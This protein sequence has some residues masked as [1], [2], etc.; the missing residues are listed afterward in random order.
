M[1]E[2]ASQLPHPILRYIAAKQ[3]GDPAYSITS[4]CEQCGISRGAY[5][6]LLRGDADVGTDL[7]EKVELGTC[8]VLT[9]TELY[10][11]W[12]HARRNPK[13]KAET[14]APQLPPVEA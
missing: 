4:F 2:A 11:A 9:C 7:F 3:Q 10:S 8:F 5:Y 1:T 13:P 12:L 14:E 6:R